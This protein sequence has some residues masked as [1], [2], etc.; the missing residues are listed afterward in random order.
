MR[1]FSAHVAGL[2]ENIELVVPIRALFTM[3]RPEG[4]TPRS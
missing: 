4:N 2:M 3:I 1:Q